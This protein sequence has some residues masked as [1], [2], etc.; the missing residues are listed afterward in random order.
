M[1]G[2]KIGPRNHPN[3]LFG[4]HLVPKFPC[5]SSQEIPLA[6]GDV[7]PFLSFRLG[8]HLNAS[9]VLR[10]FGPGSLG[11]SI[12]QTADV[13]KPFGDEPPDFRDVR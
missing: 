7:V 9:D 6:Y 13:T 11:V 5:K 10:Q 2:Y 12:E 3:A 8:L 1:N 4:A